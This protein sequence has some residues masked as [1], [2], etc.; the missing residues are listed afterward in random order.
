[1]TITILTP[2]S[3]LELGSRAQLI[4]GVWVPKENIERCL[5]CPGMVAS[6]FVA[7]VECGVIW[8]FRHATCV[9]V[10]KDKRDPMGPSA[11]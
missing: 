10:C 4:Q 6:V 8:K 5:G 1:M 7:I 9:C 3:A 11:S 2:L